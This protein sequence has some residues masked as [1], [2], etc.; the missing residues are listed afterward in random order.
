MLRYREEKHIVSQTSL[1]NRPIIDL[2]FFNR[3]C[4][5][6]FVDSLFFTTVNWSY[7]KRTMNCDN[8]ENDFYV[9]GQIFSRIFNI[10]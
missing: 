8:K 5:K 2:L 6:L 9:I 3:L 7:N 1:R 10:S 4:D